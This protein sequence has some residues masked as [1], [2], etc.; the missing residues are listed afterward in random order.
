MPCKHALVLD[1]DVAGFVVGRAHCACGPNVDS[2]DLYAYVRR[3]GKT[4]WFVRYPAWVVTDEGHVEFRVD[5]LLLDKPPGRYEVEFRY[6]LP[7]SSERKCGRI[8]LIIPEYCDRLGDETSL[9]PVRNHHTNY[10][11]TPPAALGSPHMFTIA[12]GFSARLCNVF[13]IGATALPVSPADAA[14]LCSWTLCK[15]V[16]LVLDDGVNTEIVR[17][18]GCSSGSPVVTRG[19]AGTTQRR[20][21]VGTSVAFRWTSNNTTNALL[22]CP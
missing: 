18:S 21:P 9:A 4:E 6:R 2:K 10:P 22:G 15:P 19:S 17:F 13:E 1:C 7:G 14:V 5:D 12:Q 3:L 11:T 20:F 8:E 16:E